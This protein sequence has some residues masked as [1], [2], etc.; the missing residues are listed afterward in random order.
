VDT[1]SRP[2]VRVGHDGLSAEDRARTAWGNSPSG[3]AAAA[4][5]TAS[6][7]THPVDTSHVP[8]TTMPRYS[9]AQP[10]DY[11]TT[12]GSPIVS[13]RRGDREEQARRI[14]ASRFDIVRLAT[15]G[16]HWGTHSVP[17]LTHAILAKCGYNQI[18]SSDV[19]T[20]HNDIIAV[21]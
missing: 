20:C 4:Q 21:H 2:T 18:A 17:V 12:P 15:P 3:Q 19:V 6:S 11:D 14:G 5:A 8:T 13:P 9:P 10:T 1:T 16:Y 7:P